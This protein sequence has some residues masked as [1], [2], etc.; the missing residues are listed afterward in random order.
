M[1]S[2]KRILL[3]GRDSKNVLVQLA[4][5][6]SLTGAPVILGS[7]CYDSLVYDI[8]NVIPDIVVITD[9]SDREKAEEFLSRRR[10]FPTNPFFIFTTC[11]KDVYSDMLRTLRHGF[12]IAME[13]LEMPVIREIIKQHL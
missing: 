11:R 6:L 2:G 5:Q 7:R 1:R 12:Y 8:A 9:I 10:N 13:P 4:R 3:C